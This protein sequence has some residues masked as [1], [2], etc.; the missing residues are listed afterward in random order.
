MQ[1]FA[2]GSAQKRAVVAKTRVEMLKEQRNT[3]VGRRDTFYAP[4]VRKMARAIPK[5][6]GSGPPPGRRGPRLAPRAYYSYY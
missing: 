6:T 2:P 3:G 1:A 4:F 5:C